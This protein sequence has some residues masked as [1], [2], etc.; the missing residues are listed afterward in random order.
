[1]D[2]ARSVAGDPPNWVNVGHGRLAIG[3]RP[4]LKALPR[5]KEAGCTHLLT[6]LGEREG[7]MTIG[8]AAQKARIE[9]LWLPLDNGDPLPEVREPE[10]R[11]ML[12]R[13]V[14]LLECKSSILVHC[15][16]GIHR[17]GMITYALLRKM[18]LSRERALQTLSELRAVTAEG[19]GEAR[20]GWGDRIGEL[21]GSPAD[22]TGE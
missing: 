13:L 1:M 11:T 19:V 9:W 18:G 14:L 17:T 15:S 6:L 8:L 16:A 3:H 22:G 2:K 10:V 12:E 5:L 21:G 20:L 4:K 7:A